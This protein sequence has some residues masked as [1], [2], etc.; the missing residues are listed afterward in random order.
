[1]PPAEATTKAPSSDAMI[2]FLKG[3][4]PKQ[5]WMVGKAEMPT[6]KLPGT[7]ILPKNLDGTI[8]RRNLLVL[9]MQEISKN[10]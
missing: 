6:P 7:F 1:V 10:N 8:C 5:W 3:S 4:I 9:F 2:N